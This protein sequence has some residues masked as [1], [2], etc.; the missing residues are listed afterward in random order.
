MD[1]YA[2]LTTDMEHHGKADKAS[3]LM[4]VCVYVCVGWVSECIYV[5]IHIHTHSGNDTSSKYISGI[6]ILWPAMDT[7]HY[8]LNLGQLSVILMEMDY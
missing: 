8:L 4:C 3:L 1:L 6:K 7:L 2:P 5:Y